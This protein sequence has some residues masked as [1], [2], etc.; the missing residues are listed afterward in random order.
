MKAL[1]ALLLSCFT[2]LAQ[3]PLTTGSGIDWTRST[4]STWYPTNAAQFAW[5]WLDTKPLTAL[6]NT[7]SINVCPDGTAAVKWTN[8]V[9]APF[10]AAYD[11]TTVAPDYPT[12]YL[13][14]GGQSG[15]SGR[16]NG[17]T[18]HTSRFTTGLCALPTFTVMF[19]VRNTGASVSHNIQYLL[20][21]GSGVPW[22]RWNDATLEMSAGITLTG[23]ATIGTGYYIITATFNGASSSITTN[24]VTYVS[25]NAGST[26]FVNSGGLT[27]N[28]LSH[29]A[30][31]NFVGDISRCWG[32][33]NILSGSDLTKAIT[34]CKTD[35]GFP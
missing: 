6:T 13:S 34:Q 3:S 18:G 32:W 22:L 33:S 28:I 17:V 20:G 12:N 24:G 23:A 19:V 4:S 11:W 30:A 9:V 10:G 5:M 27:P 35:F 26:G 29:F 2:V 16:I 7:S 1:F 8:L 21:S 31:I 15:T 25:G 14:G